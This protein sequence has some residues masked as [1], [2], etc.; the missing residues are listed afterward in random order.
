LPSMADA[1][2]T[3]PWRLRSS[4]VSVEVA[5]PS[6]GALK[7]KAGGKA[8]RGNMSASS[9]HFAHALDPSAESV[10]EGTVADANSISVESSDAWTKVRG[11]GRARGLAVRVLARIAATPM[12]GV[13]F[14][15]LS[16]GPGLDLAD[17]AAKLAWR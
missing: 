15:V 1:G 3:F 9:R 14:L 12:A 13:P 8:Q 10:N 17:D 4:P 5:C 16:L 11:C 7:G 2:Q 6:A